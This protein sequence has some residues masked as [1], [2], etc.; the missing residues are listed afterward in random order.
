MERSQP[1][2]LLDDRPPVQSPHDTGQLTKAVQAGIRLY[3]GLASPAQA[4]PRRP[5]VHALTQL[6]TTGL[7]RLRQLRRPRLGRD[8][9]LVATPYGR[10]I[11]PAEDE[12]LVTCVAEGGVLEP[13]TTSII[14]RLLREGDTFVDVGANIGLLTLP[15]ARCVGG[16]GMVIAIE[17][18]PR[19]ADVLRRSL[20]LNGVASRVRVE[21]CAA[22]DSFGSARMHV[23]TILGHSSL[24]P[25]DDV[26]QVIEVPL[27]RVD[28]IVAPGTKVALVKIDAEGY[29]IPVWRGMQRTIA[30][31]PNLALIVEFGP[32]H[33][34]RANVEISEWLDTFRQADF[35]LY[36]IDELTGVCRPLRREGLESVVSMNLLLVRGM[37]PD[38][39]GA[40]PV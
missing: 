14:T 6:F 9:I 15:A 25:L 29:E 7:D 26:R 4:A 17:P 33:L 13:G 21:Q 39:V 27:R 34:A 11:V 31:N 37:Y 19:L 36:E 24:L 16:R 32:S 40:P 10:L 5:N 28:A 38:F 30:D 8:E 22:A 1:T 3:H 2:D 20:A 12:A 23:G 35:D 18:V